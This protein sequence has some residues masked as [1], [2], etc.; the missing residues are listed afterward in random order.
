MVNES[1]CMIFI[2]N[3]SAF[4][5]YVNSFD[6][7]PSFLSR[8]LGYYIIS[9]GLLNDNASRL[10]LCPNQFGIAEHLILSWVKRW[11]LSKHLQKSPGLR[12]FAPRCFV[13]SSEKNYH[14]QYP[15]GKNRGAGDWY[16]ISYHSPAVSRG[17]FKP[18]PTY[19]KT[20][21][22]VALP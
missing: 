8:M 14:H 7:I 22:E 2:R 10:T 4:S 13:F 21:H 3:P 5:I 15:C 18:Q 19:G 9:F 20:Y 16:T 1:I 17:S 6:D 11:K 12:S